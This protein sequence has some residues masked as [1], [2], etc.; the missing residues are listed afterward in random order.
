MRSRVRAAKASREALSRKENSRRVDAGAG[1]GRVREG[2]GV[3]NGRGGLV[4]VDVEEGEVV[5]E[6]VGGE[7]GE[8]T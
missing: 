3:G 5:D 8:G 2:A 7:E 4:L 6:V 1:G